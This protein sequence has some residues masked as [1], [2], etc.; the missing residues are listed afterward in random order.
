MRVKKT[1]NSLQEWPK[2]YLNLF[3]FAIILDVKFEID[4]EQKNVPSSTEKKP[5]RNE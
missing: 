3:E 4:H 2:R 1:S 5:Y